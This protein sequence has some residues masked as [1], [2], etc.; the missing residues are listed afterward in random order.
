M[1]VGLEF[2]FLRGF[3]G[4]FFFDCWC[5]IFRSQACLW[6]H[7]SRGGVGFRSCWGFEVESLGCHVW[8]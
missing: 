6:V 7:G 2:M 4:G 1:V 3:S 5:L 8:N